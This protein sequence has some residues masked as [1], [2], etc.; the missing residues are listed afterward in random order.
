MAFPAE[1]LES[2]VSIINSL[3]LGARSTCI[4]EQFIGSGP[5]GD[6]SYAAPVDIRGV[7]DYTNKVY[8]RNAQ[9]VSISAIL[10]V[11]EPVPFNLTVTD[12]PRKN[13]IDPRDRITLP[14]GTAG[15]IISTPGAVNNPNTG[16]GFIQVVEIGPRS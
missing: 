10:T 15:P 7:V 6:L 1:V 11:T 4:L 8:I 13:P 5:S 9:I 16:T 3:T 2:G 12:P 14:D